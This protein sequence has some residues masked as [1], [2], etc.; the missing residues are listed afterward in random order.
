LEN[1]LPVPMGFS[2]EGGKKENL[3]LLF[4]EKEREKLRAKTTVIILKGKKYRIIYRGPGFL[5]DV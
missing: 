1:L 5:A 2:R 4:H 3:S